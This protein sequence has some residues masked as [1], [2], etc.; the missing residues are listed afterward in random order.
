MVRGVDARRGGV[1][2]VAALEDGRHDHREAER[3]GA[4]HVDV[5]VRNTGWRWRWVVELVV[6]LGLEL[7][8][9]VVVTEMVG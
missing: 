1:G 5:P 9:V 3:D 8:Y 2:A 6:E 4:A 7:E